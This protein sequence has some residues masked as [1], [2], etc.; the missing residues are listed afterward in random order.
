LKKG[1]QK[2]AFCVL[3]PLLHATSPETVSQTQAFNP[4]AGL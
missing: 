4:G 3:K 1:P 2:R